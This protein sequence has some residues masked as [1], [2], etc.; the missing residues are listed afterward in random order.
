[1]TAQ[2]QVMTTQ[3]QVMTAQA[4]RDVGLRV[5]TDMN[6]TPSI[7]RDFNRMN[8]SKFIGS[9]VEKDLQ[10]FPDEVCKILDTTRVFF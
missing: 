4:N 2:S 5:N 6:S 1:M 9:K 7:L 10:R 8:P 3:A